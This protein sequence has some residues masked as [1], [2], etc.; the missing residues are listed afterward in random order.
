MELVN[1]AYSLMRDTRTDDGGVLFPSRKAYLNVS[2]ALPPYFA[3]CGA[4][5]WKRTLESHVHS[6]GLEN[7]FLPLGFGSFWKQCSV[8]PSG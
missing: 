8:D 3:V 2:M 5:K 4:V 1:L 7:V 6:R